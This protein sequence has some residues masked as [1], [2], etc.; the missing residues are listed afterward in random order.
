MTGHGAAALPLPWRSPGFAPDYLDEAGKRPGAVREFVPW[1]ALPAG[2]AFAPQHVAPVA[3]S[4]RLGRLAEP[5]RGGCSSAVGAR[6]AGIL[7]GGSSTLSTQSKCQAHQ[8]VTRTHSSIPKGLHL[9]AQGWPDS[10]RA[11]PGCSRLSST[12]LKGLNIQDLGKRFTPCWVVV[13]F[14]FLFLRSRAK[15]SSDHQAQFQQGRN[16]APEAPL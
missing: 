8:R 5:S 6:C 1:P 10:Q 7:T 16:G 15:T 9:S 12:T 14:C 2:R 3:A 13:S 4:S 11:Y